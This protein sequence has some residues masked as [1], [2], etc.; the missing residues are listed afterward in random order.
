MNSVT[1]P[2]DVLDEVA[3]MAKC[4]TPTAKIVTAKTL[5]G[6][7]ELTG[8][9]WANVSWSSAPFEYSVQQLQEVAVDPS[10]CERKGPPMRGEIC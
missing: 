5:L 2:E 7:F 1:Y 6:H 9:C 10:L 8:A 3:A 4:L